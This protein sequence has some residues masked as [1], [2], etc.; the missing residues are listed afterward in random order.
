MFVPKPFRSRRS[1]FASTLL[2]TQP[3]ALLVTAVEEV[4]AAAICR[5]STN[6]RSANTGASMATWTG[7][8]HTGG[9]WNEPTRRWSLSAVQAHMS[10][11]SSIK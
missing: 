4:F 3:W 9:T 10:R 8:I 5:S 1:D 6:P 11:P 2:A 7:R